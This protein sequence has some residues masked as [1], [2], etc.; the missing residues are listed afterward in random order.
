M[1]AV[2]LTCDFCDQPIAM[3]QDDYLR[4]AYRREDNHQA[5]IKCSDC[6]HEE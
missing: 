1:N 6:E 4:W 5:P 3:T 2:E